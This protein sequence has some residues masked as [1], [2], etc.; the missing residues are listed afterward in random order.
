MN[1]K[2]AYTGPRAPAFTGKERHANHLGDN[3][4]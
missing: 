3:R 4:I 2:E 1:R